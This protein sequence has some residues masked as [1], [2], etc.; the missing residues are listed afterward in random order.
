MSKYVGRRDVEAFLLGGAA[1]YGALWLVV[2]S[3]QHFLRVSEAGGI[4]LV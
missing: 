4:R 2:E 3:V 1:T